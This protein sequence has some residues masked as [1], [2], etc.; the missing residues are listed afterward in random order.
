[1]PH[2]ATWNDSLVAWDDHWHSWNG[3]SFPVPRAKS[4]AVLQA[5]DQFVVFQTP[6]PLVAAFN[7]DEAPK[8]IADVAMWNDAIV[9]WGSIS[10]T[11]EGGEIVPAKAKGVSLFVRPPELFVCVKPAAV[12]A[13]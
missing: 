10:H 13:P 2:F 8:I 1:M 11:W 3:D 6:A 4:F 12:S 9:S 5:P 7:P